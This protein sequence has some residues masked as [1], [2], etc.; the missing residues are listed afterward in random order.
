MLRFDDSLQNQWINAVPLLDK[1]GYKGSFFVVSDAV[2]N[3]GIDNSTKTHN[4]E[5]MSWKEFQALQA[6]GNEI[7]DHSASHPDMNTL[8]VSQLQSEV[9]GSLAMMEAHGLNTIDFALPY[10]DGFNQGTP[11]NHTLL[12][13]IYRAGFEHVWSA[14]G[15]PAFSNYSKLA[16]T[17]YPIDLVDK[18]TS[19]ST[20]EG[21][22]SHASST[23]V[24]GLEFHNIGDK[25][26]RYSISAADFDSII[27]Y[28]HSNGFTVVLPDQLPGYT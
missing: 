5:D 8:S 10:G 22:L 9:L 1:Y 7:V 6:V 21:Y 20:V 26:V 18:D 14:W 2:T 24:I 27:N 16:T 19:L 3:G 25:P 12:H 15:T 28:L 13:Y 4:W 11:T 23:H 17:W